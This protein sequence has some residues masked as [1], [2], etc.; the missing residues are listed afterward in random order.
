MKTMILP[1]FVALSLSACDSADT[2]KTVEPTAAPTQT[3]ST[4]PTSST[5]YSCEN[6]SYSFN[7]NQ[8]TE[9]KLEFIDGAGNKATLDRQ[10]SASGEQFSSDEYTLSRKGDDALIEIKDGDKTYTHREC[11]PAK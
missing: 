1:L 3:S 7:I 11:K 9:D 2:N 8:I 10:P 6:G 5:Q 4:P